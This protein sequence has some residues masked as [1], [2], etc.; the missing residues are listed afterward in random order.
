V[1]V[2]VAGVG[3]VGWEGGGEAVACVPCVGVC[4]GCGLLCSVLCVFRVCVLGV[5]CGRVVV[6]AGREG[7]AMLAAGASGGAQWVVTGCVWWW[8][9]AACGGVW[10]G[11]TG[12]VRR[13]GEGRVCCVFRVG[14][15][16]GV[17]CV[18]LVPWVCSGRVFWACV[19]GVCGGGVGGGR[20]A[21]AGGGP[22]WV[23]CV[24]I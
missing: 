17:V 5:Q 21:G 6:G 15:V 1:W 9:Q 13:G 24:G 16:L 11:V 12:V 7:R 4:S 23:E 10:V 14:C 20:G 8:V 18:F 22:R 2:G 19:L 3:W